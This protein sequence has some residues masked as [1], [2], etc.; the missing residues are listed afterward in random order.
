MNYKNF[1][2]FIPFYNELLKKGFIKV[3]QVFTHNTIMLNKNLKYRETYNWKNLL[4]S[5]FMKNKVTFEN[6][7]SSNL[8]NN[9]RFENF[10]NNAKEENFKNYAE[11]GNIL[12]LDFRMSNDNVV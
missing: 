11:L 5:D 8:F 12:S 4:D 10:I 6:L 7:K 3:I 9:S 1:Y 2:R